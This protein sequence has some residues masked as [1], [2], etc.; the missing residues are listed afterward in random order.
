MPESLDRR[1][2]LKTSGAAGLVAAGITPHAGTAA[3]RRHAIR[4][5]TVRTNGIHMH[6]AEAGTG[7]TVLLLHGFPEFW[8]SWRHQLPALAAAG[9]H[10]VAP[11]LRGYGRTDAPAD[12]AGY[13]L[14]NN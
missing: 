6:V 3:S 2:F 10:A 7:P 11:D 12:V 8:Y 13:S 4:H 1:R 9:F 14:R 5:R